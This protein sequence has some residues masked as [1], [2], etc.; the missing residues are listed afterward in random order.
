MTV[1]TYHDALPAQLAEL[2]RDLAMMALRPAIRNNA[3]IDSTT[4]NKSEH[5]MP[6]TR[7]VR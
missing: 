4:A 2:E 1:D 6:Q 7:H 5:P 3:V